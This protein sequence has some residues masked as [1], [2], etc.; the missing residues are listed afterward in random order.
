[1]MRLP[2][3]WSTS[4]TRTA[5]KPKGRRTT[6]RLFEVT[7]LFLL[8]GLSI[9]VYGADLLEPYEP[10][11]ASFR[12]VEVGDSI[13]YFKERMIGEAL[14]EKDSVIYRFDRRT[15]E[16]VDREVRW[17]EDLSDRLPEE[18]LSR[19][20]AESMVIGKV[21]FSMLYYISPRSDV[22]PLDPT[23]QNPCWVVRSMD[24]GRQVVS[25]IDAV[26]GAFLGYGVPPPASGYSLSGPI[27]AS[28][29]SD[30]WAGWYESAETWFN[31]MGFPT[32][33]A[34]WPTKSAIQAQIQ[35][36]DMQMFYEI[37]HGGSTAFSAGCQGGHSLVST[38][39]AEVQSW[40]AAVD[41]KPFSFIASCDGMCSTGSGTF[42]HA[43]R[44]GSWSDTV[45]VGYCGMGGSACASCWSYSLSWQNRLF[46]L[47]DSGYTVKQ[48][49]DQ[50]N[51]AYPTCLSYQCMRFAGDQNFSPIGSCWDGDGD[52][53]EDAACGGDDCDDG[54]GAVHPGAEEIPGNGIDDD[55]DPSTPDQ[56]C[57]VGVVVKGS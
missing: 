23:P 43:L 34:M 10:N 32:V 26:D 38:S 19:E 56:Q 41:K 6:I 4:Q 49:F 50:A 48:A 33:A 44:K 39:A 8:L 7:A 21:L 52:G 24:E 28:P 15:G 45:T 51:A 13:V 22:F 12:M 1:M 20:E 37:A 36:S 47:M 54:D 31:T 55:C 42:S 57:F 40:M 5:S 29:C 16:L 18:R 46:E 2:V 9:P 17:R 35:S 25:I 11:A 30:T 14:V 27:Y 53:Y 3:E